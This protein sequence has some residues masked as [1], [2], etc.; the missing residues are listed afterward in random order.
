MYIQCEVMSLH[1]TYNMNILTAHKHFV[2]KNNFAKYWPIFK[3]LSLLERETN[4]QQKMDKISTV[5]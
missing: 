5:P 2:L 1:L 4:L 3:I